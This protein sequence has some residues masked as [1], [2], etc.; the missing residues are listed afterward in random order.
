MQFK[1]ANIYNSSKQIYIQFKRIYII[2][3]NIYNSSE[4]IQLEQIYIIQLKQ[5]YTIQANIY[6]SSKYIQFKQI[7]IQTN[8]YNS[9]EYI[10]FKQIYTIQTNIY[11]SNKYIQ[12]KQIY[13]VL[14]QSLPSFSFWIT[15]GCFISCWLFHTWLFFRPAFTIRNIFHRALDN[16]LVFGI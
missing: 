12:F 8:I 15:F 1:Q 9:S 11:N 14:Y 6:N 5:I 4:Y 10:Q 13:T 3:A 2:Q 16:C 7:T